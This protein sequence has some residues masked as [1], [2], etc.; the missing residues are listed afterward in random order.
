MVIISLYVCVRGGGG[1]T[2]HFL[3]NYRYECIQAFLP[4]LP[5]YLLM[6]SQ[7]CSFSFVSYCGALVDSFVGP[8]RLGEGMTSG[9]MM[10]LTHKPYIILC[11][12][13][14]ATHFLTSVAQ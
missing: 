2:L 14:T 5:G 7:E 12:C 9:I 13:N 10:T 6:W 3:Y 4:L 8:Y 11:R 1:G